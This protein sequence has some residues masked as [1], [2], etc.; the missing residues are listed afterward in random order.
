MD[1][2]ISLAKAGFLAACKIRVGLVVESSGR[3]F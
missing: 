2:S 3:Y 1:S